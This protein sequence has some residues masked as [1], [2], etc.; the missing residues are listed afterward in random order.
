MRLSNNTF[1][2]YNGNS[3]VYTL[4]S[5]LV[6]K[7]LKRKLNVSVNYVPNA[8]SFIYELRNSVSFVIKNYKE[9][10]PGELLAVFT[11]AP[12]FYGDR[13]SSLIASTEMKET[14]LNSI[15]ATFDTFSEAIFPQKDVEILMLT[16]RDAD[17]GKNNKHEVLSIRPKITYEHWVCGNG[18]VG[19]GGAKN[20]ILLLTRVTKRLFISIV[21]YCIINKYDLD[22]YIMCYDIETGGESEISLKVMCDKLGVNHNT[23]I[24]DLLKL[25]D[26]IYKVADEIENVL[27]EGVENDTST[28]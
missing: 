14:L 19:I 21:I 2:M 18:G 27:K 7:D 15:I 26:D 8:E 9:L 17:D 25:T 16:K 6:S 20:E 1:V 24:S 11:S 3:C 23:D 12:D 28:V 13:L 4:K 5:F 22:D 10:K